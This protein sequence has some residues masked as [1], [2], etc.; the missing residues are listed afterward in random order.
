[1]LGCVRLNIT[2][3]DIRNWDSVESVKESFASEFPDYSNMLDGRIRFTIEPN[4]FLDMV[5]IRA[6]DRFA[7]HFGRRLHNSTCLLLV[8]DDCSELMLAKDELLITGDIRLRK[9]KFSR[10]ESRNSDVARLRELRCGDAS[11]FEGLF[12]TK[13]V[14]KRFYGE[15]KVWLG[16]LG[17][18]VMGINSADDRQHYSQI[19][20]SRMM[21][22]Y[23][24]Q[25][26]NFLSNETDYLTR[27]FA[28]IGH[29]KGNFY[30]DFLLVLFFKVLNTKKE[31]REIG[32]F[33]SVP[34]LNGGLFKE[35]DIEKKYSI[36]I[37]NDIFGGILEFLGGWMWYVDE[38]TEYES[39]AQS[40]NPE[41]LGH[42]FEKTI[43]D[44]SSKGAYYTPI[45][46]TKYICEQTI[47]PY[48]IR[49]VNERFSCEHKELKEILDNVEHTEYL[50]FDVLKKITI[51]DPSCGSGEFILTASKILFGLYDAAWKRIGKKAWPQVEQE[52]DHM[53]GCPK[54]YFKRHIVTKN[55]YGVDIENGA[56][57]ICK[58][59]L[60]LSL[61]SEMSK[62]TA[63][64]LPNIDY[65][66]MLG[67]SLVGYTNIPERQQYSIDN[68]Y[69]I[70][71]ILQK[72]DRLKDMY[73]K[74]IDPHKAEQLREMIERE[75]KPCNDLLNGAR[76]SDI[77]VG[78]ERRPTAGRMKK[79]NP[80]HWRLH[81]HEAITAGGFDIIVGNPPYGA[82]TKYPTAFLKTRSTGNTYAYFAEV[83][84]SLLKMGGR[85]GYII[86]VSGISTKNMIPLQK[87]LLDGCSEL[88]IS[89]YD[90][91]PGKLFEGLQDC[92]S[93]IVLGTKKELGRNPCAVFT[94]GYNRWNSADRK[95]LF[96]DISY[97]QIDFAPNMPRTKNSIPSIIYDIG[98]IPKL[99]NEQ[100]KR[101]LAKI[102]EKP[103]LEES[104]R[105]MSDCVV[106]YHNAPRYWIRVMN[107]PSFRKAIRVSSHVKPVYLKN[108]DT[109]TV[110]LALLNSSLFYWFFI[111]TSNCRDLTVRE[112]KNMP[113]NI[114]EFTSAGVSKLEALTQKL[115]ENYKKHSIVNTNKR[116]KGIMQY[117]EIYP[118]RGKSIIDKVDDI[119][120]THY[121]FTQKERELIKGFDE[122]FRLGDD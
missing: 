120:A 118:K 24:I 45:D 101:V 112:I 62:D 90:D 25:T 38:T 12:D 82:E 96:A 33:D 5:E 16:R 103:P 72:V 59:R 57:E 6:D 106:Y 98:T 74:E 114:D 28:E 95:H 108:K 100:E 4:M 3:R 83:S 115:M 70:E 116:Q 122:K 110:T 34:F 119:L 21:F 43:A 47:I 10:A 66:I 85:I 22:L 31:D 19:L 39:G 88:M 15:Y 18:S 76:A 104:I 52:R 2:A 17:K 13:D 117:E 69:R 40:I 37:E 32:V 63:D 48:C 102:L 42:I 99:K 68:P 1:M 113:I 49:C 60:W 64:P 20:L 46:V 97:T 9:Y 51:L 109:A 50:Y 75:V 56:L 121:D 54:Y 29:A 67:N 7:D 77:A 26:K 79:I 55:L 11:S 36:R 71:K 35:H 65:N 105:N 27:Q 80:F 86:P 93:S 87:L 78:E 84:I 81:F 30:S 8:K 44:Q 107:V 111:K 92:R 89:N 14:V 23:F 53:A 61:V 73:N 91:R 58:L 94:T 41:I